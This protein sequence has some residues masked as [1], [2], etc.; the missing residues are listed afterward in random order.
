MAKT[1]VIIR[2]TIEPKTPS[3]RIQ[4]KEI[5]EMRGGVYWTIIGTIGIGTM[6][7]DVLMIQLTARTGADLLDPKRGKLRPQT[8]LKVKMIGAPPIK[9]GS[10]S[11]VEPRPRRMMGRIPAEIKI[12]IKTRIRIE[13]RIKIKIRTGVKA[14]GGKT[15]QGTAVKVAALSLEATAA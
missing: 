1:G 10:T 13:I 3:K 7:V 8:N 14:E 4:L 15:S 9:R 6:D 5:T 12:R 2:A 11:R